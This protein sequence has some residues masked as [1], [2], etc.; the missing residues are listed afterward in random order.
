MGVKNPQHFLNGTGDTD[1]VDGQEE[2][3]KE[4]EQEENNELSPPIPYVTVETL[5]EDQL[6][7]VPQIQSNVSG[8]C[9]LTGIAGK[10]SSCSEAMVD[11][12]NTLQGKE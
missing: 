6:C 3:S 1:L 4:A 9:W 11:A 2:D 7:N 10:G 5:Y 8:W 12:L